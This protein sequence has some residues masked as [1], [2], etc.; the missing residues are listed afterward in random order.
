V[1]NSYAE[2]ATVDPFNGMT[3]DSPGQV[4]NLV[5]GNW[6]SEPKTRDDIVDPLNGGLFLEVPDTADTTPFLEGIKSCLRML[7]AMSIWARYAP[8]Q[9]HSWLRQMSRLTL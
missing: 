1:T 5:G 4:Q 8:K 6:V 2:F 7:T 9:R 3:A